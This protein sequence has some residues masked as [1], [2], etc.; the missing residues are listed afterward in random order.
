M[1]GVHVEPS[2]NL[3]IYRTEMSTFKHIV[4]S[5]VAL[6]TLGAWVLFLIWLAFKLGGIT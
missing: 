5:M 3:P 4:F 2:L 1:G 6:G